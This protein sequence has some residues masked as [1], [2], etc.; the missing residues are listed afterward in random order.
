MKKFLKKSL[1]SGILVLVPVVVT[2]WVLKTLIVWLDG[3]V[4]S[5][6]P[7][8]FHPK[9][10]LGFD[11]PGFGLVLTFA[12]I[13]LAGIFTRLYIG[14][15]FVS[16][17]DAIFARL[18]FGRSIYQATKQVLHSTLADN[19]EKARRVVLVEYPISGT[20]AIGF[21]TG[22]WSDVTPS[23][24][25]IEDLLVFVPTAPNPTSG[26]LL[27]VPEDKVVQTD[28]STEEASK[29]LISGGLLAKKSNSV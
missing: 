28:L 15:K 4:F 24:K 10:L 17:G 20:Y 9:Q 19:R 14:K 23:T 16:L 12:I 26:F 7:F 5:F 25:E 11:I 18:P 13:L 8:E 2:V 22:K 27:I 29:L 3:L 1:V 21:L 6:I